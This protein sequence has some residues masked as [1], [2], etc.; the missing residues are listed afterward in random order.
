[1]NEESTTTSW[2]HSRDVQDRLTERFLRYSAVP[3]QSD[4][5]ATTVPTS[6]GQWELAR[7]LRDELLE[8]G[9][10]DV[11]LSG[12]CV[13]TARIPSTLPAGHR[14]P[15]IGFCTH[16]DT[17]DAGLSPQVN[18]RVV[19]HRGGD[20]HLGGERWI[21]REEHPELDRYVGQRLLVTDGTS[22]LG[23]D[24]KAALA[25]VMEAVVT[26]LADPGA[27]HPDI[28][29][30]FVP[31]EEIGL[32]GVRTM[33]LARFEVD[34]AYTVDCCELGE[35]VGAT[36][37]AASAVVTVEGVSAH[38]MSAYGVLVNPI[39]VAHD[40][41]AGLDR[42][43]TPE[44]TRGREGFTWVH[45]IVGD[46]SRA[47]VDLSIRDH[48]RERFEA[49]KQELRHLVE[50][51]GRAHP[52]ARIDLRIDDVY[53][54]IEDAAP[55]DQ[56]AWRRLVEAL[57]RLGI[58]PRPASMRGGTDGSWLSAQG[59]HTPN[60]FTGAHN[61][62][63]RCEFLPLPSFEMSHRVVLDLMGVAASADD[64]RTTP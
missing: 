39:L 15:V 10:S 6:P 48:D 44:C 27:R 2:P 33:D 50:V 49:R 21:R 60:I 56:P 46:Q 18:A 47:R 31:D 64:E 23:A 34:W 58:P 4:A 36:F 28:V 20:V 8:A 57:E 24:D 61:F 25:A 52:R 16:L 38:P 30:S 63:S 41:I 45:D 17:A 53:A 37:N 11:H 35:I 3:S 42:T 5:A 22:V 14:E 43:Q 54:N 40:L 32:R 55:A 59:I 19:D 7:M 29:V 12:T 9:A 1:M 13:L 26:V 51:V 62:H